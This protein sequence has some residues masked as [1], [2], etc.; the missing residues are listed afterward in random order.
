MAWVVACWTIWEYVVLLVVGGG[1]SVLFLLAIAS[2]RMG[3]LAASVRCRWSLPSRLQLAQLFT[4]E[5]EQ[6]V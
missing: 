3:H 4:A 6:D 1:E 5:L 2:L